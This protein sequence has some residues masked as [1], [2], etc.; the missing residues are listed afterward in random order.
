MDTAPSPHIAEAVRLT[1][2]T[3]PGVGGIEKCKVRKMGVE[4]YVDLHVMVEADLTVREGHAIAHAVK[5]SLRDKLPAI[6]DVLVHI[7]PIEPPKSPQ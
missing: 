5:D 1:A 6:A 2:A 3:V 4:F 7:E